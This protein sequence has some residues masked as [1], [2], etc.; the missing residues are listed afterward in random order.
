MHQEVDVLGLDLDGEVVVAL[1]ILELSHGVVATP[2]AVLDARVPL[3]VIVGSVVPNSLVFFVFRQLE[4]LDGFLVLVQVVLAH[5]L[6][7]VALG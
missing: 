1:R 5:A 7:V 2:E 3:L 6:E 4:I